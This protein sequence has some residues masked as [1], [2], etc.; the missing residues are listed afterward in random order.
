MQRGTIVKH[1]GAFTLLYYD[2]QFRDGKKVVRAP[3]YRMGGNKKGR[4]RDPRYTLLSPSRFVNRCKS[5]S[6]DKV[7]HPQRVLLPH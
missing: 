7:P 5:Y 3:A 2:T 6:S 4:F 1:N